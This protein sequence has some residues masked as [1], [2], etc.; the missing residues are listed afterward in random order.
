M[1]S[2][3]MK[4]LRTSRAFSPLA[5]A[6]AAVMRALMPARVPCQP[7]HGSAT[8]ERGI[9]YATAVEPGILEP[10]VARGGDLS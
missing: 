9:L 5:S 2:W 7:G 3:S 10:H 4:T 8:V 1:H 6:H